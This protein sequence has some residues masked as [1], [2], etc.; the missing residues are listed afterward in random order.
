MG[1]QPYLFFSGNCEEALKTYKGIFG[2]EI[3]GLTRHKDSPVEEHRNSETPDSVMHATFESPY[4]TL[5]ASDSRPTTQYGNGRVSLSLGL[6]DAAQAQRVFD[7]LGKGGEVEMPMEDT[8]WGAR[9][10]MLTDRFGI[11]WMITA[12]PSKSHG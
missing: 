1:L 6:D 5:M 9:F 10:G 2:G 7:A 4:F 11:D 12:P 8:F 3:K